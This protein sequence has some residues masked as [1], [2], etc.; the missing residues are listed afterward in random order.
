MRKEKEKEL[1]E[2]HAG[3]DIKPDEDDKSI[4]SEDC[5]KNGEMFDQ[6]TEEQ[7]DLKVFKLWNACIVRAKGGVR[8]LGFF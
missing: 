8:I 2:F 4:N 7:K 5:I 1:L 6:L 3:E